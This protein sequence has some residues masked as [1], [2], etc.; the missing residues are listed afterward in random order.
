LIFGTQRT[1]LSRGDKANGRTAPDSRI[2]RRVE[3]LA[4]SWCV[5]AWRRNSKRL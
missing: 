1:I 5:G 2:S 4:Q 3:W